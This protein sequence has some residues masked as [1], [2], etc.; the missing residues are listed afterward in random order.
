MKEKTFICILALCCLLGGCGAA[1]K[2]PTGS[3]PSREERQLTV[4]SAY[5]DCQESVTVIDRCTDRISAVSLFAAYF[6]DGAL[7]L[8]EETLETLRALRR[9]DAGDPKPIYL[10]VVNDVTEGEKTIQKDTE[11]LRSVLSPHQAEGHARE[12]VA[13][14]KEYGFDGIEIDYEKLREDPDLWEQFLSFEEIL[15]SLAQEAGLKVRIILE[16]G[17]PVKTLSFPQGAAYVVMCYNLHGI[18]TDPGPK[19]DLAF[20]RELY[21]RFEGLPSL[22]FALANGGFDWEEASGNAVSLTEGEAAAL[23]E[24]HHVLPRRDAASG[25]LSFSYTEGSTRHRVWYADSETL[26]RWAAELDTCAGK[27]VPIS[28]WRIN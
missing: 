15:L 16:P 13:L 1:H 6:R 25:A 23:A 10:S 12:L 14:A 17:I 21:K 27:T 20:L 2:A 8:P 5:W 18:G 7:F 9:S 28:I 3:P 4:W 26:A 19:A 22:S 24:A 11:I